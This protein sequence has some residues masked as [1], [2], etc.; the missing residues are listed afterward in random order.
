[1]TIQT[2]KKLIPQRAMN[3]LRDLR[4][5]YRLAQMQP[6][7]FAANN[8]I[9]NDNFPI[10]DFLNNA[11]IFQNWEQ[12]KN[13]ITQILGHEDKYGGVNPGDRR[14]IYTLI[15]SLKPKHTLEIGTHIGASTLYIARALKAADNDGKLTTV[16]ILDVN[17]PDAPWKTIGLKASPYQNAK[18]LDCAESIT[19]TQS[20]S[21]TF[22]SQTD[23]KFD[24][25]FLDGDHGAHTVYEEL[26]LA[27]KALAPNG[28]IL[29]HDYY[30][31]GNALFPDNNIIPG[32]YRALERIQ[33]ENNTISVQPLG[34]LP[35]TTKQG[36]RMTS[37]AVITAK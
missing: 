2:I 29:L 37:L 14:A 21:T 33:A 28:V 24:F 27:L 34:H 10:T 16:D 3:V 26:S 1:M 31:N 8:L 32:P 11:E 36:S 17:A 5:R 19:F 7:D 30:T 9:A 20:G 35:W 15:A 23:Q 25:I 13:D 22:L 4:E 18:S 6:K 12:D